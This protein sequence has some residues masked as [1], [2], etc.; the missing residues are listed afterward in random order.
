MAARIC[1]LKDYSIIILLIFLATFRYAQSADIKFEHL[2]VQ[3]GLSDNRVLS[4]IQDSKGFMWFGTSDGLNRYD[5]YKFKTYRHDPTDSLSLGESKIQVLYEDHLSELWIGTRG[6]G[7][8]RYDRENDRF[9]RY[10]SDKDNPKSLCGDYITSIYQTDNHNL[11][12]GTNFGLNR[13]NRESNDFRRYYPDDKNLPFD[14]NI[15]FIGAITQDE[16]GQIWIRSWNQGLFIYDLENDKFVKYKSKQKYIKSYTNQFGEKLSTSHWKG[17]NY[18][19]FASFRNGL[20]KINI[21]NGEI[22]HYKHESD[23]PNSIGNNII[24]IIYRN[25]NKSNEL[26][27]GTEYGLD[28]FDMQTE[29]FIHIQHQSENSSSRNYD[30]VWSIYKDK[31]GLMW[32]GTAH[33]VCKFDPNSAKFKTIQLD[34]ENPGSLSGGFVW[35][36]HE[37]TAQEDGSV[38]WIGTDN[39]LFSF[40]RTSGQFN[41][42][43]HDSHIFNSLSHNDVSEIIQSELGGKKVLWV[44]TL[45]GLNKI[46]LKTKQITRYYIPTNDPVYNQIYTHCEDN[47]G[48]IWIGTQTSFLYS[49][50]P[51]KEQ[52]TQH[53]FKFG[54]IRELYS[55]SSSVLWIGTEDGLYK[56]NTVTKEEMHYQHISGDLTSISNNTVGS[57]LEDRNGILWIG[58][59]EGL[60]KYNRSTQ[61]FT[62]FYE[63]DGLI[64]NKIRAILEDG[65]GNLWISTDKGISKFNPHRK[66]WNSVL[67]IM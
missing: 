33:G 19:W 47:N 4:I 64:S 42:Y 50:D 26:W 23:N 61:T 24:M 51:D 15:N 62:R 21:E 2:T 6:G 53:P 25:G 60:N 48:I 14:D 35:T 41:N 29:K 56:F 22:R 18:L 39:G 37:S 40:N 49:F 11:W 17:N 59:N 38:V 63:K 30:P 31:S 36:I 27:F 58:T 10:N 43:K 57:I 12:I 55:A 46:D 34:T 7:L 13:Y 8:C 28:R 52:F 3:D 5:G 65:H 66:D 54:I 45:N 9:I 16:N 67:M 20:F 1:N 32:V 44:S